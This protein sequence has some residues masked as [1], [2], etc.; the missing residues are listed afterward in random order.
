MALPQGKLM[1]EN[2]RI[3][4][5]L[6]LVVALSAASCGGDTGDGNNNTGTG[7]NSGGNSCEARGNDATGKLLVKANATNN[8]KFSSTLSISSSPT[9]SRTELTFDWSALSK[10][11]IGHAVKVPDDIDMITL[12]LWKL[13]H[14]DLEKKLNDDALSQSDLT[15][16]SNFYTSKTKSTAGLFEFTVFR[17][18]IDR[19]MI[20]TYLDATAYDPAQYTYTLMV[21]TGEESGKGTRMLK[22]FKP[23][24]SNTTTKVTIDNQS[25]TLQ[26]TADL[27]SLQKTRIPAGKADITF[28]WTDMKLNAMGN[29]FVPTMIGEVL[30]GRYTETAAELES[31]FLDLELMAEDMYRGTVVTG[32]TLALSELK[33]TA[34]K[35]FTGIDDSSTWVVALRCAT[36][37]N[38]APWYLSVLQTCK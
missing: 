23:D 37:S 32:S 36:C 3:F 11:F 7:G 6:A 4:G 26:Y 35:A 17:Q 9:A 25:T 12:L 27:H 31:K 20:L 19:E 13:S 8:Y 5:V 30:V 2:A 22:A 1:K 21:Q 33:T 16:I 10:D 34:G 38:P 28:D 24:T 15:A 14:A 18:P 29:E